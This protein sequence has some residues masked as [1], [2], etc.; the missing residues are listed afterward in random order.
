MHE[1]TRVIQAA[2]PLPAS[3][4]AVTG[5]LAHRLQRNFDRL[6]QGDYRPDRALPY[7]V[8]SEWPAD[9]V[10]RLILGQSWLARASHRPGKFLAELV[11]RLPDYL[12]E[13]GYL[14][15]IHEGFDEQQLSG[16][17]WLV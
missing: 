7:S 2:T 11:D 3:Q 14:G 8:D 12:N 6:E 15:K 9:Y 10:G 13:R 16:H 17:G 1:I 4:V 5:D